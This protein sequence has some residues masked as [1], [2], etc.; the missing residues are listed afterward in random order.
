MSPCPASHLR[1]AIR[2]PF[3]HPRPSAPPRRCHRTFS[4]SPPARQSIANALINQDPYKRVWFVQPGSFMIFARDGGRTLHLSQI[5]PDSLYHEPYLIPFWTFTIFNDQMV[6]AV[7]RPTGIVNFSAPA[8]RLKSEMGLT[9]A[10]VSEDHWAS[11]MYFP[12][13]SRQRAH[14]HSKILENPLS[15]AAQWIPQDSPNSM[16]RPTNESYDPFFRTDLYSPLYT[17][18][19]ALGPPKLEQRDMDKLVESQRFIANDGW[20]D[21]FTRVQDSKLFAVP[22]YRLIYKVHLKDGSIAMCDGELSS[23][24][25]AF[26]VDWPKGR[27]QP[28]EGAS[29]FRSLKV[30]GRLAR[31]IWSESDLHPPAWRLEPKGTTDVVSTLYNAMRR[32]GPMTQ[33]M[34]EESNIVPLL[35]P[36]GIPSAEGLKNYGDDFLKNRG[37]STPEPL[38][39]VKPRGEPQRSS[40]LFK[41]ST[42]TAESP[43]ISSPSPSSATAKPAA[44]TSSSTS[45]WNSRSLK[46]KRDTRFSTYAQKQA[47]RIKV[48]IG[49]VA[50]D[51][52]AWRLTPHDQRGYYAELGLKA[53]ADFLDSGKAAEVDKLVKDSFNKLSFA[54]HPDH[55]GT[56]E[57]F[58]NLIVSRDH[59]ES[60]QKRLFY[61]K[62]IS[63]CPELSSSAFGSKSSS[64]PSPAT[65]KRRKP[66]SWT[67]SP[68]Y[69]TP[70][71]PSDKRGC[72]AA[73]GLSNQLCREFLDVGVEERV[74][75]FILYK[76]ETLREKVSTS[77]EKELRTLSEAFDRLKNWSCR[78]QYNKRR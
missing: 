63:S 77:N 16:I 65:I 7:H 64:S 3:P 23:E 72:Y 49:A 46:D 26:R 27:A 53:S 50:K 2:I 69:N 52:A 25:H 62:Q 21:V 71:S 8:Q 78:E 19:F 22:V 76:Y 51:R 10:A 11:G 55:G 74:N 32:R 42:P 4:S 29:K 54:R 28:A 15:S 66:P 58:H 75:E 5:W 33:D 41:R 45:S 59:V 60:H 1:P 38:Y 47:E 9:I 18:K 34:W 67:P 40:A 30:V 48:S 35:G 39:P 13:W 20:E 56:D 24:T 43:K 57:E 36:R 44:R 70:G 17:P 73:L 61:N 31:L 12:D 14:F 68:P 37:I 6:E